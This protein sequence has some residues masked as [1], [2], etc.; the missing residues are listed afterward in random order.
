MENYWN[1]LKAFIYGMF[2]YLQI[3]KDL[4]LILVCLILTDMV[5]GV[6]KSVSLS[7]LSFSIDFFWKGLLKKAMLL[8]III[9]LGLVGKALGFED[10]KL[11]VQ[12]VIKIMIIN[13]ALSVINGIR[14]VYDKKIYKNNDIISLLISK[15]QNYFNGLLDKLLSI[16]DSSDKNI[17]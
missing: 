7:G 1:Q 15:I 4:A 8:I 11:L 10:F 13:E 12:V 16:F 6:V 2:I 14:S 5:V 3:D 17:K 9:T